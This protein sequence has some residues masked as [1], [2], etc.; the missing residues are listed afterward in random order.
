LRIGL[1]DVL[2]Q[3]GGPEAVDVSLQTLQANGDPWEIAVLA[4]NLERNSH[5]VYTSTGALLSLLL[6]V[7]AFAA[8]STVAQIPQSD[9]N[10]IG[11]GQ[12]PQNRVF[13]GYLRFW[14]SGFWHV[15]PDAPAAI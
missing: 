12:R 14:K 1:F 7:A 15:E 8:D 4:R 3:V 5:S 2:K 9:T 11:K 6:G 13:G 10:S